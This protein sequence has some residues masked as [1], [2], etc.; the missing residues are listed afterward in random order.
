MRK[1]QGF[2][3]IELVVVLVILG[4]LAA[5]AVPR[6]IDLSG[7]AETAALQAQ[8]GNLTSAAAM[9]FAKWAANGKPTDPTTV[10]AVAV[11]VCSDLEGLVTNFDSARFDLADGTGG[12]IT[13]TVRTVPGDTDQDCSISIN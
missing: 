4:I 1:A 13:F 9:N 8:A 12:T 5:V 11:T 10:D 3:L 7:E 2:T 6:F